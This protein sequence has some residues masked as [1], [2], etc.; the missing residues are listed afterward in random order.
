MSADV[1]VFLRESDLPSTFEWQAGIDTLGVDM[2]LHEEPEP[3]TAAGYWPVA[4]R[5]IAS[6]FEFYAGS[7]EN[8]FGTP[9]PEGIGE[10]DFAVNLV[11]HSDMRELEC[12]LYAAAALA[13]VAGGVGFDEETGGIMPFAA[14]LDEAR[15]IES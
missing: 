2:R 3:N 14:L 10:R 13:S 12:S 5:G 11:T 1:F 6:G 7:I 4:I 9:T 8:A 15:S